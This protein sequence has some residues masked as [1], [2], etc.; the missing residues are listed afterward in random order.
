M[1]DSSCFEVA[2]RE[3]PKKL[4]CMIV[5]LT[6]LRRY[7]MAHAAVNEILSQAKSDCKKRY[8]WSHVLNGML[9]RLD[10]WCDSPNNDLDN[11]LG[12]MIH[13]RLRMPITWC[14]A[15]R[16]IEE[17]FYKCVW[18]GLELMYLSNGV[19]TEQLNKILIIAAQ[20][21]YRDLFQECLKRGA[22]RH[23]VVRVTV[24]VAIDQSYGIT[25]HCNEISEHCADHY[26][27]DF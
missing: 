9:E 8:R 13:K 12:V 23:K 5:M 1:E 14:E 24:G 4:V 19:T 15:P 16:T 20:N 21:N 6:R 10:G 17:A 2:L 22:D 26:T 3:L 11:A 25:T 18:P 7:E 27:V